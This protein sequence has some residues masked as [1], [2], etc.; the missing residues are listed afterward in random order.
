MLLRFAAP[1]R[2]RRKLIKLLLNGSVLLTL[3][4]DLFLTD[5]DLCSDIRKLRQLNK[6]I[7]IIAE[8]YLVLELSVFLHQYG[9]PFLVGC[10][11]AIK[12][13]NEVVSVFLRSTDRTAI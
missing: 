5:F 4:G 8:C 2:F 10:L 7:A 6:G 9:N 1:N 11:V 3:Q 12:L 13:L